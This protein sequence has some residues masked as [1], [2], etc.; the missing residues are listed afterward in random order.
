MRED[1]SDRPEWPVAIYARL[2][3]NRGGLSTNTAIQVAEC[4]EEAGYIARERGVRLV[5]VAIFA[6]GYTAGSGAV[7]ENE[8]LLEVPV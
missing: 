6:A 7:L 8:D 5:E 1:R 2:S 3:K 4:R